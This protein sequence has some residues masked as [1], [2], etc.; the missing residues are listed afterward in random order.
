M[1]KERLRE[2]ALEI[3]KQSGAFSSITQ[4]SQSLLP[5]P[6]MPVLSSFPTFTSFPIANNAV[7]QPVI[8]IPQI[9]P[10]EYSQAYLDAVA[11]SQRIA[12]S[13]NLNEALSCSNSNDSASNDFLIQASTIS[14]SFRFIEVSLMER[15][16]IMIGFFL[17]E[18]VESSR[19]DR[20][21]RSRW[22]GSEND[23]T[24]IPGMPT[25]LPSSLDAHQQE[26][27]LGS[28]NI[29]GLFSQ[30]HSIKH[31]FIFNKQKF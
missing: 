7:P 9:Q 13:R 12:A 31:S 6:I 24:F 3:G 17:I 8:E 29:H 22:G 30:K 1:E 26:A 28:Y 20:K 5:D 27:Y 10:R 19:R 18:D 15:T 16:R 11:A 2:I 14:K 21:K 25:V 4:Q 23:K